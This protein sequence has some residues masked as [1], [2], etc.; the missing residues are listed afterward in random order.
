MAAALVANL[1][2]LLDLERLWRNTATYSHG[3]LVVPLAVMLWWHGRDRL[4]E[5]GRSG[6]FG[7]LALLV[8]AMA[9][10]AIC[11]LMLFQTG[12]AVLLPVAIGAAACAAAGWRLARH[13]LVPLLLLY[14]ATPL[15]GVAIPALQRVSAIVSTG[16]VRLLGFPSARYGDYISIPDGGL[17]EVAAGCSGTNFL[18]VSLVMGLFLGALHR[19]ALR[20]RI[21][22]LAAAIGVA[23][24]ANWT[25]I[26]LLVIVGHIHGMQHPLIAGEHYTFGWLLFAGS[27]VLLIVFVE[28]RLA[29]GASAPGLAPVVGSE[30]GQP[31]AWRVPAAVAL[32]FPAALLLLSSLTPAAPRELPALEPGV[33]AGCV[34]TES[35]AGQIS[36]YSQPDR[37]WI[38]EYRCKEVAVLAYRNHYFTQSGERELI[39]SENEI[40]PGQ[41]SW[42]SQSPP[43]GAEHEDWLVAEDEQGRKWTVRFYYEIAGR[44]LADAGRVKWLQLLQKVRMRPDMGGITL[45]AAPCATDC[46]AESAVVAGF[47]PATGP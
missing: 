43:A 14:C 29:R 46:V 8:V 22:I 36:R 20:Q 42:V 26:V 7:G 11:Q 27:L 16:I 24:F 41:W 44:R 6:R 12:A 13:A 47:S 19:M 25:R 17:F 2:T 9:G 28:W 37:E 4:P 1:P 23:L 32:L 30:A 15:A 10:I 18:L 40:L 31:A 34:E 33:P 45:I 3:Y 5:P 39:S 21:A 35:P 38:G